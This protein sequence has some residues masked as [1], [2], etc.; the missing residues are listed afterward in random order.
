[1]AMGGTKGSSSEPKYHACDD[2][3][4]RYLSAFYLDKHR[5]AKHETGVSNHPCGDC[6][7]VYSSTSSLA[8]HK[9]ERHTYH[10]CDDCQAIYKSAAFL[11]KH[12]KS[13]HATNA[14][15]YS[16]AVC[17]RVYSSASTL[18]AHKEEK[19]P[20]LPCPESDCESVFASTFLLSRHQREKHY[21]TCNECGKTSLNPVFLE[22][23]KELCRTES[24]I[25][26]CDW[27]DYVAS[28]SDDLKQHKSSHERF[29]CRFCSQT[30][31]G[32]KYRENHETTQ[33]SP[34]L[35]TS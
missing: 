10:T 27:C 2:C 17:K 20:T 23:H 21:L 29:P 30:F 25:F 34:Q 19:H 14:G 6:N 18:A 12:K 9:Q 35:K 32:T 4:L 33:H 26:P 7:S 31:P 5:K 28:K 16:C 11:V 8:R 3:P 1:M 22:R 15:S 13:K 24:Q